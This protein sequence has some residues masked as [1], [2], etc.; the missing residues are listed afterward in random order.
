M[1]TISRTVWNRHYR[2]E[3]KVQGGQLYVGQDLN[4]VLISAED[5]AKQTGG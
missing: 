3:P 2:R 1:Q 5:E 4:K